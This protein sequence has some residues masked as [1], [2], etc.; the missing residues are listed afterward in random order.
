M[1][2]IRAR[3][4]KNRVVHVSGIPDDEKRINLAFGKTTYAL[5]IRPAWLQQILTGAGPRSHTLNAPAPVQIARPT[6]GTKTIELRKKPCPPYLEMNTISLMETGSRFIRGTAVIKESHQLTVR[7]KV[8]FADILQALNYDA[9]KTYA[10]TLQDVQRHGT[11][12]QACLTAHQHTAPAC[13]QAV[14]AMNVTTLV[15][16]LEEDWGTSTRQMLTA[17]ELLLLL[18]LK[19]S[20]P[21][22]NL[23]WA[24]RLQ[25]DVAA[26][27]T[28]MASL[29]ST[30]LRF[31]GFRLPVTVHSSK[32]WTSPSPDDPL[33]TLGTVEHLLHWMED[34]G[35]GR[36]TPSE[37]VLVMNA[38]PKT[39]RDVGAALSDVLTEAH[40]EFFYRTGFAPIMPDSR[41]KSMMACAVVFFVYRGLRG[42]LYIRAP[43]C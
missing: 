23:F 8:L 42:V 19:R 5:K 41:I 33:Q 18:Q 34:F 32:T 16:C 13:E 12:F 21:M 7:E 24:L 14:F 3:S 15:H 38:W 37:A 27:R 11:P 25:A 43:T 28:I 40:A 35:L 1:Y 2:S 39:S 36:F 6:A 22:R 4:R 17:E 30:Q 20:L 26:L 10:W 31:P 29:R 9:D